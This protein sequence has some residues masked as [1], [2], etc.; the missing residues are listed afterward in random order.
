M[1]RRV[2]R[3]D[4]V[5]FA[6]LALLGAAG[7]V[8]YLQHRANAALDRQTAVILQK[9][10]EQTATSV[11]GEIRQTLDAPVFD[12][13][14]AVNHPSLREGRLDLVA[15]QFA[16]GLSDYAQVERFFVWNDATAAVA[17]GE[18]IFYGRPRAAAGRSELGEMLRG[19]HR[20]P[21]LGQAVYQ[22]ARRHA[23][24]QRIYGAVTRAVGGH[25][26]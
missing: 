13:L 12:T 18:V 6:I 2:R 21:A 14:S 9:I 16:R 3:L 1:G 24:S 11:H 19:F 17:P 23:V 5:V 10:A 4:P 7:L 8:L 25:V 26:L 15:A 20:D 22:N